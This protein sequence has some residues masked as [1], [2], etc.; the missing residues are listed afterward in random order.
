MNQSFREVVLPEF[1]Q[2]LEFVTTDLSV[3]VLVAVGVLQVQF[4]EDLADCPDV[5]LLEGGFGLVLLLKISLE[6]LSSGGVAEG[7][8][9]GQTKSTN[10]YSSCFRPSLIALLASP[11]NS[12]PAVTQ[13]LAEKTR[14]NT[15]ASVITFMIFK[16]E[17]N[18]IAPH[19]FIA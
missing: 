10:T 8:D 3:T 16:Y 12:C 17:I 14:A 7:G 4:A 13:Q 1:A 5:D 11:F 15:T 18:L 19:L 6:G 9:D 2:A